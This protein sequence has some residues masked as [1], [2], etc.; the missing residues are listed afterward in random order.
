MPLS[1]RLTSGMTTEEMQAMWPDIV[2]CLQRFVERFPHDETVENILQQCAC[3]RRQLW[4]IQDETGKV[5]LAP[6]TEIVR[7]DATGALRMI[8]CIVSGDN[9]V[10]AMPCIAEMER[11]GVAQGCTEFDAIGRKGWA[12]F[13]APYGLKPAGVL[14][15]KRLGNG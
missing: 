6:V 4:V 10:D 3:G 5:V 7:V 9:I 8:Y 1:I 11:W 14:Y 15:R 2:R 13:V 12:P